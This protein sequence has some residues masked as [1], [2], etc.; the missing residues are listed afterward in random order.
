MSGQQDILNCSFSLWYENFKQDTVKSVVLKMPK[1]FKDYLLIDRVFV[2]NDAD[3]ER[4]E[5]IGNLSHS[6]DEL[7]T[8]EIFT[9]EEFLDFKSRV[10]TAIQ[11]LGGKVFPKLNWSSPK[12]AS[13]VAVNGSLCC[14]NFSDIC[15]LLK[16]SEFI[17]HDLTNPFRIRDQ[18]ENSDAADIL[19]LEYTLVLRKWCDINASGEFR[20]FIR[21]KVLIAISQ[22]SLHHF[23][24]ID[25][26]KEMTV[27]SIRSFYK[28][29]IKDRFPNSSYCLDLY[30]P[31]GNRKPVLI[32]FN[33]FVDVTDSLMFSWDELKGHK[34]MVEIEQGLAVQGVV[35][36]SVPTEGVLSTDIRN[37]AYPLD[38]QQLASGEDPAKLI[39]LL[40]LQQ[41]ASSLT[42][43]DSDLD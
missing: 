28:R 35:F 37:S 29:H 3:N 36:R 23:S 6:L 15:L 5:P 25:L 30:L 20:C 14:E 34:S 13:W 21:N 16:S 19:H 9:N 38:F 10:V 11:T 26:G 39:D 43:S 8:K 12:D 31:G 33:P 2:P 1:A 42:S 18:D 24:F 4:E 32:D 27:Q 17:T 7:K 40:K 22:R 41:R